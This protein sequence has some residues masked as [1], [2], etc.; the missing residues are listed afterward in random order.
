MSRSFLVRYWRTHVLNKEK[1]L[2]KNVSQGCNLIKRSG[3]FKK[4]ATSHNIK[5]N[6]R[7]LSDHSSFY[8]KFVFSLCNH[9]FYQNRLINECAIKNL[10]I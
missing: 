10:V 8:E 6:V 4:H 5:V 9:T 7:G 3:S 2:H 1:S